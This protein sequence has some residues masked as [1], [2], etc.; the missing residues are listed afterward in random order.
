MHRKQRV[1]YRFVRHHDEVGTRF[2]HLDPA[3]SSVLSVLYD[4][5]DP[6]LSHI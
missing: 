3:I 5:P 2:L 6:S 1:T 4:I